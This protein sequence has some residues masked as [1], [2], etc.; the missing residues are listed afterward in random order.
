MMNTHGHAD[1]Q[2][3]LLAN[4]DILSEDLAMT[5]RTEAKVNLHIVTEKNP[6]VLPQ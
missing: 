4:L 6:A 1:L 2:G 3:Q 5:L